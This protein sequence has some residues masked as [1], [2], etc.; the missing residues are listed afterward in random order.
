MT[1][2]FLLVLFSLIVFDRL[3]CPPGIPVS[4]FAKECVFFTLPEPDI[5]SMRRAEGIFNHLVD[6]KVEED[7]RSTW[8]THIWNVLGGYSVAGRCYLKPSKLGLT[9]LL[10]GLPFS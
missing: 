9:N 5:D 10:R 1:S 3:K 8:T 6:E 4:V 2:L 7:T